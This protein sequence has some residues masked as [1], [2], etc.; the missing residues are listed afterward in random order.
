MNYIKLKKIYILN[1]FLKNT[2][3]LGF[4]KTFTHVFN[5][6]SFKIHFLQLQFNVNFFMRGIILSTSHEKTKFQNYFSDRF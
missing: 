6:N 5:N 4:F 3:I 1:L 2:Q